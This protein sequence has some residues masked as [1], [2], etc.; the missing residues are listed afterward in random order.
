[1]KSVFFIVFF[2]IADIKINK[3]NTGIH[4]NRIQQ[5][6]GFIPEIHHIEES[7]QCIN[8]L[9]LNTGIRNCSVIRNLI[10]VIFCPDN[11][12]LATALRFIHLH[13]R[14]SDHGVKIL[15]AFHFPGDISATA[16]RMK[17]I[18]RK[19]ALIKFF[20]PY[21]HCIGKDFICTV[22]YYD[23]IL[24]PT[25]SVASLFAKVFPGNF[26]KFR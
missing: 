21:V 14:H 16:G 22:F 12:I 19:N 17:P 25:I 8:T 23:Q 6:S 18:L 24:I 9:C 2:K 13:I 5:Y 1:M 7:G 10:P 26:S 3:F 20:F 11:Q 15:F 4:S